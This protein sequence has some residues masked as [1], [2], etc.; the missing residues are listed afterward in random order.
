MMDGMISICKNMNL[1]VVSF[2]TP[3]SKKSFKL[4]LGKAGFEIID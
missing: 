2:P 4:S 1:N 3:L